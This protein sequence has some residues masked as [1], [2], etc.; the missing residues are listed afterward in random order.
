[1]A[2][3]NSTPGQNQVFANAI[4]AT[5]SSSSGAS[6]TSAKANATVVPYMQ[7]EP[8]KQPSDRNPVRK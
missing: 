5:A 7:A 3:V 8:G 4:V 2:Q 6:D 1:M